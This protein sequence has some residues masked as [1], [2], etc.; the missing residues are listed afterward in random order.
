MRVVDLF[1]GCGG[2]SKGFELEGFELVLAVE[3]WRPARDVYKENF[4][5]EPIDLD[6]C[7]VNDAVAMV[8]KHQPD[9]IMGGPPCQE[10]SYAGTRVEG[11]RAQLTVNFA[12][13]ID[14]VRPK[15]FVLEN[16]MG[17]RTSEAWSVARTLL[18]DAGYGITEC[19]LNAAYYGV[20]QLRKRFFAV[21]CLAAD[22][23][24]IAGELEQRQNEIP[25]T[26]REYLGDEFGIE[27]YYRHPRNW[28]RKG[29]FSVNEPSPTVRST[30][31][32]VPPG[33]TTHPEDAG[34]H[35]LARPLSAA[36]R[37]RIQTFDPTFKLS[38]T[39]HVQNMM[40][41]NAV[42]VNLAR[43]VAST[44]SRYERETTVDRD[45]NFRNWLTTEHQYTV[46]TVSNVVSRLHRASRILHIDELSTDPLDVIHALERQE[47]FTSLTSSVRSQIKKAIR[48]RSEFYGR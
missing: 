7:G 31:R 19:V 26:I 30:N 33:Y 4:T 5:H 21:G 10:F 11:D 25:M 14:A 47:Q 1:S 20:P 17:I 46:R 27:Y 41:A 15:W 23:N 2:L 12:E 44:I 38:G 28:G 22:D 34:P 9:L 18:K 3:H 40:V 39:Q 42:P 16:V 48:L 29:V 8:S 43:H 37:A 32:P 6:L 36:E 45:A 24:F 13:I 35:A